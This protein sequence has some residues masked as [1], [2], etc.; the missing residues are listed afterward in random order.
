MQIS[1]KQKSI[2]AFLWSLVDRVGVQIFQFI[3]AII[4]ARILL[5][6]D[7]GLLGMLLIFTALST[8]LI[9]GGFG[10]ALIRQNDTSNIDYSSVFYFNV[11]ISFSLY[12]VLYLAAP[13]I[14]NF[15]SAPQLTLI[16]R[17]SFLSLF[18][19]SFGLIQT[20]LITK[21]LNFKINTKVNILSQLVAGISSII[22]ALK[23]YGVWALVVQ[24]VF[25]ALIRNILLWYFNSWR[26]QR[27]FSLN[28]LK[29]LFLFSSNLMFSYILTTIFNNIY[30]LIIGKYFNVTQLGYYTQAKRLQSIPTTSINSIVQNV[31]YPIFSKLQEN[32]DLLKVG[33]KKLTKLLMFTNTFLMLTL[34]TIA[35]SLVLILLTKKW[36]P[37]VGMFQLICILGILYPLNSLNINI[38]KVKG[39]G[40]LYLKLD[41]FKKFLTILAIIFTIRM[42]IYEL[43]LGN[44]IAELISFIV[45]KIYSGK[46]LG[47]GLKEYFSDI[48]PY[49]INGSLTVIIMFLFQF[50][51]NINPLPL[52]AIQITFGTL[53]FLLFSKYMQ[54]EAYVEVK[55]IL[56]SL[57]FKLKNRKL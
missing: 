29:K 50:I 5:P 33:Y 31:T 49:I 37:M 39:L 57:Y 15:Y 38:I 2:N 12:F 10:Q 17:V 3:T 52:L 36:V 18:I 51:S 48:A 25:G 6:A 11:I 1:L 14:S 28:S 21:N 40:R 45:V 54:L 55:I 9:E 19:N 24:L 35:P 53:I 34:I 44:I 26:P 41:I 46:V 30:L 43:I 56:K 42:G 7:Y 22:L 4:V 13:L 23:G 47:Y 32:N 8:A 20:T 27:V 16:A